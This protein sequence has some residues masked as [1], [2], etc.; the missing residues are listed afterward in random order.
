MPRGIY[1][2]NHTSHHSFPNYATI[3]IHTAWVVVLI[4]FGFGGLVAQSATEPLRSVVFIQDGLNMPTDLAWVDGWLFVKE[5][6]SG[7]RILAF[8]ANTGKKVFEFGLAG[9][10]P[11]EYLSFS[12]QK[13]PGEGTLEI[14][15]TGNKKID[16][17]IVGCLKSL[18][19]SQRASECIKETHLVTASRQA[20]SLTG[21]RILNHS[22]LPDGILNTSENGRM[23][24][25]IAG[26]PDEVKN[27][28]TR[29]GHAAMT[30]T[31]RVT[32]SPDRMWFAY[33]A[34]S[35]DYALFFQHNNS[36]TSLVRN[37]PFTFLPSF[38]VQVYDGGSAVFLPGPDYTY[39]FGSPDSGIENYFVLYSGKRSKDTAL[40]DDA[41]WRAFT[42][43]IRVFN[44]KGEMQRQLLIDTEVFSIAVSWD[45]QEIFGIHY[46]RDMVPAIIWIRLP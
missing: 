14:S 33:F 34:D 36:E 40:N 25:V 43:T 35:F 21:N 15:D 37:H 38:D 9:R 6:S 39:T 26:I 13:G 20:I 45:E 3:L 31:G 32:A 28:Y 17:Y 42:N 24:R 11:G 18:S 46:N 22:A 12:I 4:S 30:M 29:P 16:I 7:N 10:G 41:E 27:K 44:R 8:D 2:L 5:E 23:T 19:S 1:K